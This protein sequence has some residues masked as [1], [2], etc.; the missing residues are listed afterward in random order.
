MNTP[1]NMRHRIIEHDRHAIRRENRRQ[2]QRIGSDERVRLGNL[3]VNS[4]RAGPPIVGGDN[5]DSGAMHLPSK[6]ELPEVSANRGRHPPPILEHSPRVI[7]DSKAQI[8]RLVGAHGSSAAPR[9]N[10]RLNSQPLKRRPTQKV[11]PGNPAQR[12]GT[13]A[14]RGSCING[15]SHRP[16]VY[17]RRREAGAQKPSDSTYDAADNSAASVS[18]RKPPDWCCQSLA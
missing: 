13:R 6:H 15:V 9:S 1:K 3:R 11:K 17:R 2:H 7:P 10:E 14:P 18:S 8:Q 12:A 16:R 4:E 5:A